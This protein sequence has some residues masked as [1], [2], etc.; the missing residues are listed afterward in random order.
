M[1]SFDR[2]VDHYEVIVEDNGML[3]AEKEFFTDY[4]A[5]EYA[6]E[7]FNAGFTVTV[8]EIDNVIWW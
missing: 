2:E 1:A 5:V 6:K 3:Y 8:K 7:A 4:E